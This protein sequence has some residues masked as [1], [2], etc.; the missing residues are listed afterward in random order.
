MACAAP[1][2]SYRGCTLNVQT[3]NC[4]RYSELV[5]IQ[6]RLQSRKEIHT[7]KTLSSKTQQFPL[8]KKMLFGPYQTKKKTRKQE[9]KANRIITLDGK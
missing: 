5:V 7:R 8:I 2:W 6:T 4:M 3:V 1:A 9:R